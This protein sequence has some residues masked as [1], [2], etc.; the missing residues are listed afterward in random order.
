VRRAFGE[1]TFETLAAYL[2]F[3][4]TAHYWTE[5]HPELSYEP[6]IAA[7][8]QSHPDLAALLLDQTEAKRAAEGE[9]LRQAMAE[10]TQAKRVLSQ[11]ERLLAERNAQLAL[12]G[13][14]ALV[15]SY[16]YDVSTR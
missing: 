3:I 9:A 7:V 13:R 1:Q 2:A 14:A 8:M 4:R 15:G 10:L 5:T 11:K 12:A 16:V 6:D